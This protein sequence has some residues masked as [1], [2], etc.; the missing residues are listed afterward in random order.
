MAEQRLDDANIDAVLEEVG[1]EAVAQR[2][3]SDVLGDVG[4]FRGL[5]NDAIELPRA[6][7]GCQ[8]SCVSEASGSY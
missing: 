6:D 7:R 3:R 4:G 5:D 2:V 8:I 1:R